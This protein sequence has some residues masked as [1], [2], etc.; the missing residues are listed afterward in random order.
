MN[1]IG[2]SND[3]QSLR[4]IKN[5]MWHLYEK[6]TVKNVWRLKLKSPQN[7][8]PRLV[9]LMRRL[10]AAHAFLRQCLPND[11]RESLFLREIILTFSRWIIDW[12]FGLLWVWKCRIEMQKENSKEGR[13]DQRI[14]RKD[15]RTI[16]LLE[17][18]DPV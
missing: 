11:S 7:F 16:K 14:Q 6:T 12:D 10:R 2:F 4:L 18:R 9:W 17:N 5:S 13:R 3:A 15:Q 1:H 8:W